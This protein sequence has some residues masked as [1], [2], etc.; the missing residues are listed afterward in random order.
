VKLIEAHEGVEAERSCSVLIDGE[1][2][3]TEA[4]HGEKKTSKATI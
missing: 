1:L 2:R 4:F 3:C